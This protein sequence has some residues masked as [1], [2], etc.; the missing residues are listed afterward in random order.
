MPE[1]KNKLLRINKFLPHA[2]SPNVYRFGEKESLD[3]AT[4]GT[5]SANQSKLYLSI[6]QL[7]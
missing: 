5:K 4:V 7:K 2:G 1:V 6:D 3:S